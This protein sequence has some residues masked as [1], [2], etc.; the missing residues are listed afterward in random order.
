MD[1]FPKFI[2]ET[3]DIEGDSLIIAK[4]TYHKQLATDILKVKGGGWWSFDNE[5]RTYT[6]YGESHDF[7]RADIEDIKRCIQNGK[8]FSDKYLTRK[9]DVFKFQYRNICDEIEDLN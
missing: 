4:C 8:V 6:L 9:L 5:T 7:G 1:V 2:I 3:D